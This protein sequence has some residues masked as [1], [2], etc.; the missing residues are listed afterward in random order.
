[1]EVQIAPNHDSFHKAFWA[2]IITC[3]PL[4]AV[5]KDERPLLTVKADPDENQ[6][7]VT[8]RSVSEVWIYLNDYLVDLDKEVT[9]V[10]NG[11]K[12]EG[13]LFQRSVRSL[14]DNMRTAYDP[15]ALYTAIHK[16]EIPREPQG[17]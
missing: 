1:L 8:S 4:D 10:I 11:K 2:K 16:L 7:T 6:I 15:T 17:K 5:K 3:E 14:W 13:H 12:M 9:F